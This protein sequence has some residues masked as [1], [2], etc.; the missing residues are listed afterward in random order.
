MGKGHYG[1]ARFPE[2][3]KSMGI[4]RLSSTSEDPTSC[5]A[6]DLILIKHSSVSRGFPL[7]TGTVM[8]G[9][10]PSF[11]VVRLAKREGCV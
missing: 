4:S 1:R 10:H 3:S 6:S 2:F 8:V 7:L 9:D 11:L 5:R